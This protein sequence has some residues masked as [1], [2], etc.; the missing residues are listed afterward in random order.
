M[1]KA[2]IVNYLK[3]IKSLY[4]VLSKEQWE[5]SIGLI[6]GD[7]SLNTQNNGK[8]YRIKFEWSDKNKT[9]LTQVYNLFDEWVLSSPHKK[10]RI[11]ALRAGQ[12]PVIT[13]GF[14]TISPKAFNP[15]A[16]LFILNGKKVI[17]DSLIKNHLNGRGLAYWFM[18]DGGKLDYN[19]NSKNKSVVLNTQ[20]FSDLEVTKL[21][22]E[23]II[24]FDFNCEI[25]SNKGR[26][27]IVINSVSYPLFRELVDP[28]IIP[29]MTYK[30]P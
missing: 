17:S 14:Q 28:Y 27:I 16:E 23:L 10:T 25:R 26:K 4:F 21:A 8:T 22:N 13:W 12:S 19:K 30:L 18:D 6:L 20:G 2:P 15:L 24:K 11:S 9:Y 1:V 5:A 7:A 29:E 3:V